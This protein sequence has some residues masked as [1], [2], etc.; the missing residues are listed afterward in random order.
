MMALRLATEWLGKD[1]EQILIHVDDAMDT[2]RDWV[3]TREA[4]ELWED[5]QNNHVAFGGV[6]DIADACKSPQFAHRNFFKSVS[7]STVKQPCS[8]SS[9]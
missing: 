7:G 6:L 5:A 1:V 4:R 9:I 8:I 3:K 2:I